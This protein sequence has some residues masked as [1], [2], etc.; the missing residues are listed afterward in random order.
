L[1]APLSPLTGRVFRVSE[2][3]LGYVYDVP[4]ARHLALGFGVQGTLNLVP[5]TIRFAYGDDPAGFMPFV[6]LKIR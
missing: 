4:V 6:R 5:S 1:F 3:S 2:L